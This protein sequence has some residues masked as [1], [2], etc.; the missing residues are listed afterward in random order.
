[1]E[2]SERFGRWGVVA[3]ASTGLGA[4]FG[5]E[6]ARRGLDVLLVARRGDVLEESAAAIR[7]QF[8]VEVRTLVLDLARPDAATMVAA[9]TAE[10]EVG[11]FVY[12]AAAEPQGR[13]LAT[14]LEELHANIAVN[15][16]TPTTL[17]HRLAPPMVERGRGG[18]VLVSSMGALQGIKVF[19]AY[20]A[21]KSYELILGEGL[22]DELR[23]HGVDAFAYVVGATATPNFLRNA[24]KVQAD[25]EVLAGLIEQ[26]GQA[27]GA[28]RSPEEVAAS[29]FRVL[30]GRDREPVGPRHYS[31][32]DD[33]ARAA[34]DARRPRAD[35]VGDM[36]RMTSAMG[37]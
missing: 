5:V 6:A 19:A 11:L 32:P 30:D 34:A 18:V 29:C 15:C 1:V 8:P 3:G 10:L 16:T 12:N 17:V 13:F 23:D 26:S 25:P 20:G 24:G 22:W 7:A 9:A 2:F 28:P 14:P 21:A 36:G 37:R 4:A 35:V 31:H 27:V 33:E